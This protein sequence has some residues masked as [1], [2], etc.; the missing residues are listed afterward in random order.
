MHD[1][2][3]LTSTVYQQRY[4]LVCILCLCVSSVTGAGAGADTGKAQALARGEKAN[5]AKM[6]KA[7]QAAVALLLVAALLLLAA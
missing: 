4:N 3:I 1:S 6:T 2:K 5:T 7:L